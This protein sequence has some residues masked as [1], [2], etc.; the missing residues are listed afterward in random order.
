M[1]KGNVI[2]TSDPHNA[3]IYI[4]NALVVDAETKLPIRTPTELNVYEG[5]HEIVLKIELEKYLD[6]V[7]RLYVFPN[8]T[9]EVMGNFKQHS[10]LLTMQQL[11]EDKLN[12][13]QSSY[14]NTPSH[15]IKSL[16]VPF[17][18]TTLGVLVLSFVASFAASYVLY[19]LYEKK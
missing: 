10:K 1:A 14:D 12:L 5:E 3:L 16:Q 17:I 11:H 9:I 8:T 19:R 15:D 7:I 13:L 4:D 6:E 2:L 18:N